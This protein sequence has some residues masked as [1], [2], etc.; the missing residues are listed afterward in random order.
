MDTPSGNRLRVGGCLI[1]L[2]RDVLLDER[3]E[4]LPLRPRSWQVLRH[5]AE[6]AGRVVGKDELVAAVWGGVAVT[7]GALVQAVADIRRALGEDSRGLLRTVARRGYLLLA[8]AE[9][10]EPAGSPCPAPGVVSIAHELDTQAQQVFVGRRAEL[11]HLLEM[12]CGSA[13]ARVCLLHGAGGIGKSMLLA[14]LGREAARRGVRVIT[15]DA[16]LV[17][18]APSSLHAALSTAVGGPADPVSPAD[19]AACWPASPSLLLIDTAE[20][21]EAL[22]PHLRDQLLPALPAGLRVVIA[23]RGRPDSR[24][25]GHPRWG[26]AVESLELG[27]LSDGE[28]LALLE[29]L[30]VDAAASPRA[31]ALGHGHPLT[32]TLLAEQAHRGGG[33]PDELGAEILEVLMRRCISQAPDAAHRRALRVACLVDRVTEVLLARTVS[34]EHAPALYDWLAAQACVRRLPD[35]LSVHDLVREAVTADHRRRDPEMAHELLLAVFGFLTGRLR[36]APANG[37]VTTGVARLLRIVPVFRRFFVEGVE[38]YIADTPAP[39]DRDAMRALIRQGLPAAEQ[40]ACAHWLDHPAARW[41]VIREDGERVCGVSCTLRLDRLDAA[42]RGVDPL[43]DRVLDALG[44]SLRGKAMMARFSVPEGERGPRNPSMNAL[45]CN[46]ARSWAVEPDL[47][48]WVVASVRPERYEALFRHMRFAALPGCE[49]VAD[50]VAVGCFLHDWR[51]E[52][53]ERWFEEVTRAAAAHA[54]PQA[55]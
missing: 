48:P 44:P 29:R 9:S 31:R 17:E 19:L 41:Q 27:R 34:A 39:A 54:Q 53:W 55:G 43:V 22:Q 4:P 16:Q 35:G 20:W 5:L 47:G 6:S 28:S 50:G 12:A 33:L 3:G 32:L 2:V 8:Q 26:L 10:T 1:D 24:W 25:V 11:D 37:P 15:L 46:Q 51:A 49:A 7:D 18:P 38:R 30:G 40:R 21:I 23:S 14:R 45:Q 52:P 36:A 42:D 13:G